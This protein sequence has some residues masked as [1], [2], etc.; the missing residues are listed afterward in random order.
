LERVWQSININS[1]TGLRLRAFAELLS[2]T[3]MRNGEALAMNRGRSKR[4]RVR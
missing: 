1:M 2:E 4:G 3:G